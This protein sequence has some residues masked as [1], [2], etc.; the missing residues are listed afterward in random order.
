MH[1]PALPDNAPH[2][3]LNTPAAFHP[4]MRT[5]AMTDTNWIDETAYIFRQRPTALETDFVHQ[6]GPERLTADPL[7]LL[8]HIAATISLL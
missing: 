1:K 2:V 5:P 6:D 8:L 3:A 4:S 7:A